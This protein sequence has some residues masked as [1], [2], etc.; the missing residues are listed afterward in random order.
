MPLP[1]VALQTVLFAA[2]DNCF[3]A[4][5]HSPHEW[6]FALAEAGRALPDAPQGQKIKAAFE[7][8]KRACA[9]RREQLRSCL[10]SL[11]P[12][13]AMTR[14]FPSSSSWLRTPPIER[15]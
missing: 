1:L 6:S 4:T 5:R 10:V 7:G 13:Y 9:Q 8:I 12:W 15:C 3:N 14:S 2:P 11:R